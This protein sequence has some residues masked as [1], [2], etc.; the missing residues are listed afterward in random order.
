MED[1]ITVV[2]PVFRVEAYLHRCVD[3]VLAQT[4]RNMEVILV[5]DGSDDGC[6]VICDAYA[7]QDCRVKVIH[8]EN[9]GLYGARNTGVVQA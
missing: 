4:Y 2:I 3:S 8:Q 6:P 7:R 5:Y 9:R 1:L